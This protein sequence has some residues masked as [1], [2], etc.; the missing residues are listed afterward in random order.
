MNCDVLLDRIVC[1]SAARHHALL[2]GGDGRC[3]AKIKSLTLRISGCNRSLLAC[4]T[5]QRKPVLRLDLEIN[6]LLALE[7]VAHDDRQRDLVA[8][9]QHAGRFVLDKE[10]LKRLDFG[11]SRSDATVFS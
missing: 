10:R 3:R 9:G 5:K 7:V 2:T 4:W 11:F 6:F 1:I 8:L